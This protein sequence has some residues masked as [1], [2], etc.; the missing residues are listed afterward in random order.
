M[1]G[2][3][4]AAMRRTARRRWSGNNAEAFMAQAFLFRVRVLLV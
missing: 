3:K 2:R 1:T 4:A